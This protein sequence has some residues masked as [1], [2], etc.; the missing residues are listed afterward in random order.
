MRN[1]F[2]KKCSF[3]AILVGASFFFFPGRL[4]GGILVD[5]A[6]QRVW[7]FFFFTVFVMLCYFG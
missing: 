5:L 7:V 6:N 4:L 2:C 1:S 3:S